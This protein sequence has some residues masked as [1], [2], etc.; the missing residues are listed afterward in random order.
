MASLPVIPGAVR[1]MLI[2]RLGTASSAS[3]SFG[4]TTQLTNMSALFTAIDA[5]I[6]QAMWA[7]M[8]NQSLAS[9]M[10]LFPYDGVTPTF[11]QSVSGSKYQGGSGTAD[12][13]LIA[14]AALISLRTASR[15][16]QARGRIF[17]PYTSELQ[18]ANGSLVPAAQTALQ[19]AWDAF[20]TSMSGAGVPLA[21]ISL[22]TNQTTTPP[23]SPTARPVISTTAELRLA[24]QRRRQSR[25]R[26]S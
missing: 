12:E 7:A 10:H 4:V 5:H 3:I 14:P 2:W 16:P 24:T 6:T 25:L 9:E 19:T 13:A 26:R 22:S 20:R 1:V 11:V 18:S 17:L 23:R 15:G 21:V 8:T